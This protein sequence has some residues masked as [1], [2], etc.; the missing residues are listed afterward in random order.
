MSNPFEAPEVPV[1]PD[2]SEEDAK[3]EGKKRRKKIRESRD[4]FQARVA[5][6]GAIQLTA[7]SLGGL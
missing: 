5:T 7:P 4:A 1:V 2:T 6:L 3:K